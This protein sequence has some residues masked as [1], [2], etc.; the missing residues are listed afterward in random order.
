M[1]HNMKKIIDMIRRNDSCTIM[2]EIDRDKIALDIIKK[3][4]VH[5]NM[6]VIN[7]KITLN[8]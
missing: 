1:T 4:Q 8:L 3:H 5:L 2:E 6:Q 7:L